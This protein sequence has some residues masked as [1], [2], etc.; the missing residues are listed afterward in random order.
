MKAAFLTIPQLVL[1]QVSK[2]HSMRN[3]VLCDEQQLAFQVALT[4]AETSGARRESLTLVV[5]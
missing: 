2:D 3:I 4:T 1:M 5:S